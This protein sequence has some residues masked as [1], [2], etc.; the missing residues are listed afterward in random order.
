MGYLPYQLVQD[1]SHQ[2]YLSGMVGLVYSSTHPVDF[3][4]EGLKV[5]KLEMVFPLGSKLL[6]KIFKFSKKHHTLENCPMELGNPQKGN[7]KL[8][9]KLQKNHQFCIFPMSFRE[10]YFVNGKE[11]SS[12]EVVDVRLRS[13]WLACVPRLDR[14]VNAKVPLNWERKSGFV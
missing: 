5:G 13:T 1:F 8:T 3:L 2:Q 12:Y 14:L 6:K 7:G 10:L 9:D 4:L 11:N